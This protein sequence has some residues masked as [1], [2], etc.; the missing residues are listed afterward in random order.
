MPQQN[1]YFVCVCF[2]GRFFCRSFRIGR[3]ALCSSPFPR[4]RCCCTVKRS[5]VLLVRG[6]GICYRSRYAITL[7]DFDANA[8]H[9]VRSI[10][11]GYIFV[12][13][14]LLSCCCSSFALSQTDLISTLNGL[15]RFSLSFSLE[16]GVPHSFAAIVCIWLHL[17]C[18]AGNIPKG[19]RWKSLKILKYSFSCF[20]SRSFSLFF[21]FIFSYVSFSFFLSMLSVAS[22]CFFFPFSLI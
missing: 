11:V 22:F 14:I 4:R 6:Y 9:A 20:F 1:R 12:D 7:M 10:L 13:S 17:L 2:F 3:G 16:F 21:F 18:T 8:M 5:T 19:N 15:S